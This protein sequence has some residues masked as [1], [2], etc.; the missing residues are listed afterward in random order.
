MKQNMVKTCSFKD[1]ATLVESPQENCLEENLFHLTFE[2]KD[3][4]NI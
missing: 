3:P 1:F 4:L 2:L